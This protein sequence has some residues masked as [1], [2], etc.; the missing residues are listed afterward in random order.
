MNSRRSERVASLMREL[1]AEAM[2]DLNDP[3]IETLTSITRVE[4]SPDFSL[5][6]I[7]VSVMAPPARQKLT[8]GALQ[9]AAG[10]LRAAIAPELSLRVLPALVFRLDESLQ[11]SME[12]LRL[13]DAAMSEIRE[14]DAATP[15]DDAAPAETDAGRADAAAPDSQEKP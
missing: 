13:I 3:R 7:H 1:V 5:A 15:A 14:R 6:T 2:R 11:K 12:T 9:R 8:L 4:M 10:R